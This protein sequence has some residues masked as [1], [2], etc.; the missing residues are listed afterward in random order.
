MTKMISDLSQIPSVREY[1]QRIDAEPRSLLTAVVKE[2]QGAYWCD[3][4]VI[5]FDRTGEVSGPE[6]FLPTDNE[7]MKIKSGFSE[8][9]FPIQQ[10]VKRLINL[11]DVLKN[12]DAANLFEF[13]APDGDIIMVQL[14]REGKT[15]ERNYVPYT[16]WSD[17]K[18]RAAEPED[19]L[20]LWGLDQLKDHSTVF[21]HEGAKAARSMRKMVEART[22]CEKE[23]LT[24]HP[25]GQ[26]LSGAAHVG[27]IGGALSPAR[28]D[29]A[30]LQRL[31][32]KRA[33]IVSDNDAAGLSAVPAIS[34]RLRF[35]TFHLQFT[36]E[37][38][39]SFDLAD[40][41]P[42]KM[43][44]KIDGV[45]HYV[46]PA[47]KSCIQP[48]TWA[49]DQ[50]PNTKGRPTTVMRPHFKEMWQYVEEADLFV[51]VEM[52][53]IVRSEAI[54][55]KM[56]SAFSHSNNTTQLILK[57]YNGRTAKICYRPDINA[58]VVTDR[59][60][61][62]INLHIP[63]NIKSIAGDIEPFETYLAYMFPNE[64][65][66]HEVKRWCATLIARPEVRMGYGLLLVSEAQGIGKTTLGSEILGKL[67]GDHNV[68][69]PSE[70]T[71]VGSD[72]TDWIAHKRLVVVNEI[73]SGHSWKAYNSLKSFITD[74]DVTVNA[75]YQKPYIID[76][77]ASIIAMSNSMRALRM[78]QDD[79]RWFYPEV[80]ELRWVGN[81]FI[82][83]YDW[84]G[85][86]GLSIIKYWAENFGSYVKTSDRA[87][88]TDRKKEMIEGSRT[89]AQSEVVDLSVAASSMKEP[90]ALAMKDV[91]TWVRG[92]V[93]GRV[94]DSDYELRKAMKDAGMVPSRARIFIGGRQQYALLNK[95]AL[96]LIRGKGPKEAAEITRGFLKPSDEII[97]S[98]M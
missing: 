87:P 86:G 83:L 89:E 41:F 63:S 22:K 97:E 37:W 77:W 70:Q 60:T 20:P 67:V 59:S 35:P 1:L 42:K 32:V 98:S 52:P 46:G 57:N 53:E 49:T 16:F 95:A 15:G 62:A 73:Y 91:V 85:S 21:I 93:Q 66:L 10:N 17:K 34:F 64:E 18:W 94:F 92:A 7:L 58:R 72:F 11:P 25:W 50:I 65:E 31:G 30:V 79:R 27:W 47:F 2:K 13:H 36:G 33:Y 24:A 75:K 43:F 54:T 90:V 45:S 74:K 29:W 5:K 40:E 44:K 78:E 23:K 12:A 82:H 76:N 28:T 81:E 61:S 4:A 38:P 88:M 8:F 69:Y 80:T 14:R 68:G 84:L 51:C 96:K 26:E 19:K 48:A 9:D 56:L 3:V 55:N 39:A 6:H 71:I